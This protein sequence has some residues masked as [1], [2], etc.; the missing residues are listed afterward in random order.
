MRIVRREEPIEVEIWKEQKKIEQ[1]WQELP[2]ALMMDL[3]E[4]WKGQKEQAF[5]LWCFQN[6]VNT[7]VNAFVAATKQAEIDPKNLC[8]VSGISCLQPIYETLNCDC[9]HPHQGRSIPFAI[10]LHIANPSLKVVV[11]GD[12]SDILAIG[13]NHVIHAA[14]R[15]LDMM[16]ICIHDLAI[17][18]QDEY[19]FNLP[20]LISVCGAVYLARWTTLEWDA[21]R[22]S[23][24]EAFYKR[25]FRLIEVIAPSLSE[26]KTPD[27]ILAALQAFK[28]RIVLKHFAS[29]EKE[30]DL[31]NEQIVIG[32]F[33]DTERPT[34]LDMVAKQILSQFG[35]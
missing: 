18:E 21:L 30:G 16:V 25:G 35:S 29:P 10:G 31:L 32:K 7:V 19:P 26:Q 3:P 14:R 24:V 13:G 20:Y 12:D 11:I 23:I 33:V 27:E 22:N 15:N 34:F 8:V 1:V 4:E 2:D 5:Q 9:F 6:G 28:E 17:D